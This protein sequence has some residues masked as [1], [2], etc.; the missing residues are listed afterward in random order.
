MKQERIKYSEI[1]SLGFTEEVMDDKVYF[2]EYGFD[3]CI[4]TKE[5]TKKIYLDWAKETQ[6]CEM[7]RIDNQKN[8][9]IIKR[10]AIKDFAHLKEIVDF[11]SDEARCDINIVRCA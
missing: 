11:Y 8:W 9:N 3:W 4:I 2:N 7:V 10:L 5:L 1:M 6:L